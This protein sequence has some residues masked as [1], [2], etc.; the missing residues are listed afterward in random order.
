[1]Q[2]QNTITSLNNELDEQKKINDGLQWKLTDLNGQKQSLVAK[3]KKLDQDLR[4]CKLK[5]DEL[6][7]AKNDYKA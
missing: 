5:V 1:M 3:N 2:T 7:K 4:D 6:L